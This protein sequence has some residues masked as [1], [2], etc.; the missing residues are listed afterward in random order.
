M[1]YQILC[2]SMLTEKHKIDRYID[3][4]FNLL[5]I[6]TYYFIEIICL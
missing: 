6:P 3:Y 4:F 2:S 5:G 1:C